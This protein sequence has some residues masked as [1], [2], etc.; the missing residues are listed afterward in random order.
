MLG[1]IVEAFVHVNAEETWK[2]LM[3]P[4]TET[5]LS[6]TE[7]ENVQKE[8]TLS[9]ELI[10]NMGLLKDV[11]FFIQ[12]LLTLCINKYILNQFCLLILVSS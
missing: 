5:I 10:Y 11:S 8:Q 7:A 9:S 1:H 4:I 2:V 3:P 12:F 6:I